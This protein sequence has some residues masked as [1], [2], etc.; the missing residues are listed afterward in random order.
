MASF[1]TLIK[2]TPFG[3][4]MIRLPDHI[5]QPLLASDILPTQSGGELFL[6]MSLER[7]PDD[8]PHGMNGSRWTEWVIKSDRLDP[9][10]QAHSN[11]TSVRTTDWFDSFVTDCLS[12]LPVPESPG[13]RDSIID[14][15]M[16]LW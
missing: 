1:P 15:S 13:E 2:R 9:A 5:L 12:R 3:L 14:Q 8:D 6:Q 4:A 10:D 11:S 7:T 16:S